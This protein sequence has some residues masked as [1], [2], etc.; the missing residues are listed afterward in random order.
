M[1]MAEATSAAVTLAN[2]CA[3][4]QAVGATVSE[5]AGSQSSSTPL[6]S[7][8][9]AP[10]LTCDGLEQPGPGESQQ[11]P[12]QV[13][14]PSASASATLSTV[15]SQSSSLWLP[16]SSGFGSTWP[17]HGPHEVPAASQVCVPATQG[18]TPCVPGPPW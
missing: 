3:G 8:S 2:F 5:V 14:Q 9:N 1:S 13:V 15:P 7:T 18:P 4:E 11:S 17:V 16:Q 10:G 6:L 12:L